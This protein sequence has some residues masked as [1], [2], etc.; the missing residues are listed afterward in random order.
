MASESGSLV[1][2]LTAAAG[3]GTLAGRRA[4]TL[5]YN[6][7][8]PGP[9]LHLSP[10]DHLGVDLIND[11]T[12]PTNLHTHGLQVTPQGNSDNPFVMVDPG[13]T[14]HYDYRLPANHPPG[15][16]WY[17]PHHHGRTADQVFGGLYGAV[18]ISE[19]HPPEVSADRVL[20]V[21]DITLDPAGAVAPASM[22][23]RLR[24]REGT[25]VLVN[26]QQSPQLTVR[27]GTRERWRIVNAC[28]SRY[29][30]LR[31]DGQQ[32]QLLGVDL[33]LGGRPRPVDEV[34]LAPGNR[35]DLLVTTT[36]GRAVLQALPYQRG[37]PMGMMDGGMGMGMPPASP[38]PTVDLLTLTVTGAP[39]PGLP[40]PRSRPGSGD[41]RAVPNVRQRR[42][43]LAMGMGMRTAG[44]FTID[45]RAFDA[46]RI[47]QSVHADDVEEWVIS[48]TSPMDHPFHLHIW[49]MQ[50]ISVSGQ[51]VATPTWQNVVNVPARSATVV[52]IA[53]GPQTGRSVY[54][55]HILDHEDNGMMGIVEVS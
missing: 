53:F 36:T 3:P 14:F 17:H 6:G 48:N 52:R 30:R 33:L 31:L 5:R 32:L 13:E 9:T 45:G 50:V 41:L 10:G 44:S 15:T 29:L 43:I 39:V 12:E 47:D 37:A 7:G 55:C 18:V 54:H 25:L 26:G 23:E 49:P 16:F 1:L 21:S 4:S 38:E 28:V 40:E 35:A 19:P 20:V 42:L 51:P 46:A 2:S 22:M 8:L 27:A 11:L 24:G 34:L